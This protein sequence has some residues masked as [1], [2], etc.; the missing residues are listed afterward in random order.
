MPGRSEATMY[1]NFESTPLAGEAVA[2]LE[3]LRRDAP[4]PNRFL[5]RLSGGEPTTDHLRRLVGVTHKCHPAELAAFAAMI[6]R[7]PHP[8]AVRFFGDMLGLIH[9]ARPK[10]RRVM[11]ALGLAEEEL[12]HWPPE[13]A[14]HQVAC[15]WGRIALLGTQS[16]AALA[17][18]W[19]MVRYF[20][21]SDEMLAR[22]PGTGLDVPEEFTVYYGGGQSDDLERQALQVVEHGLTRGESMDDAVF[23]ARL[24]EEAI[25]QYWAAAAGLPLTATVASA[26][27]RTL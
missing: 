15:V 20:P 16:D 6:T 11:S 12:R 23:A 17:L 22:L 8:P 4:V 18:Y 19:D 21:E 13:P 5:D 27:G 7:D 1:T 9:R 3:R 2:R 14:A 24:M 26:A 10:L 25:G